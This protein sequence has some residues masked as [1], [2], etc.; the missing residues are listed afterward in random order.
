MNPNPEPHIN[1]F[2]EWTNSC[3]DDQLIHLNVVPLEGQRPY[4]F[5]F[6]SD[7]IP[8]RND[9]RVTSEILKRYQ[10]IEEGGWWCS[11]IDLLSGEEDLWGCFKPSQPR[12][13]YDE[14]KLI[15]YEHP[16]KTPT[17]LFALKIPLHLWQK[18]ASRYQLEILPEDI[19]KNQPD[20]GFWQWFIKHP[21]IPLCITEGAKKAGAL[22]TASYIAIALPGVFGGYRVLRD[23]YG[24]RI[25]KPHLIP[26]LEKL[27]K[28]RREIYI[29]F[30][31]DTKPKTIKNVNAAIRKTGYLLRRKGCNVKVI[32]WNPELGKGVDDLIANQGKNVFDK[33]YE[34]ALLLELWK[35]KSFSRLTYPVNL[36]VNSRYLSEQN[37]FSSLGNNNLH[38]LDNLDL[39]YSTNFPAKLVGIKSAKGTGKTKLLEK[40]VAEA[41]ARHQKVLVIGHR[42]QLV[43]ELC[44]RFGLKYITEVNSESPDKLL[45]LGLCIDSLH[46]N[47][48][49]NFNP[50]TWSD[51]IVI[52]DEIEQVIWH[53]LNSNTC[54]QS[55]VEILRCFKTLMQNVLGGVGQVFIADADLSDISIDYLAALAGIKLEP[56]I[57]QNDW[58]PGEKEAWQIFNYPE[59][60]PK[61]LIA[62]LHKHIREGGKPMVCLSAQKLTSKWGTRALEAYLKKQFPQLKILRIDS[63]SLAEPNHPA[64]GCIKSLNQVLPK[65]DIV[66]AS[67]SIETGVSIDIQGHFTSVWGIAQGVQ[68]ATSVC[69]SLG[70]VRENI[71]RYLWVAN[72]GFNKVGNGSTSITSLLNSEERLTQLNIRL[73]QQSDFDSL[74]DLEVN[75]QPESF[76]CWAKMAVRFNAGMN[77]YRESVL[78]FLQK[79][80]HQ[81]R[82]I[83]TEVLSD[84][85]EAEKS[86]ETPTEVN[87]FQEVIATVIKQNYQSECEAIATAKNISLS[88]YE[89]LKK[90]L[91]KPIQKQREQRKFQLM[92]RY[93][94]PITTELVEK[95]DEGWYEQLEL[96]YFLT[97]G[98]PYLGARDKEV[99][100]KLLDLGKGNIFIPDFNDCLLGAIIGVM[101][102]LKIPSLLKDK[103]RE[104]K[105]IDPDLQL[106]GKTALSNRN[107]IKTI[108]GIGLAANSSPITIVRRFLEKIGYSLECL[109][110]ETHQK[111]RLRIYRIVNPDDGRFEIFQ[112]WL[113]ASQ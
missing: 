84:N 91:S 53:G 68:G 81:I 57:I 82:E 76:L 67:P 108:L 44:Q 40:I 49:A 36:R 74:D 54:R 31:Q 6:Y 50:E 79:E 101:E 30:D 12:H 113:S 28:D 60:T 43:Q 109:R 4:E 33:V 111:K 39:A 63:E 11:G 16:P 110:T 66:L 87:N 35:A 90:R 51:G 75:F 104:L 106:L 72:S 71:P 19:D 94:I 23:E 78:E 21:Q 25:G 55:R 13:S 77:K 58:L 99:A 88:E 2:Q 1:Y 59:T 5:L 80:G 10:H 56:F 42:V 64:Y 65:Y 73:L 103:K 22:L 98:R 27:I 9:G 48:Q 100:K 38:K 95:D 29:V 47:S 92:L 83:S 69:Q 7:A 112:Q 37:I 102:L 96:H 32:S 85:S 52:I 70:R 34:K 26:Q 86:S 107:E 93:N 41:V 15:K 18:I 89:K 8:R 105:N 20:L 45:G 46:P 62:D 97:V 17:S 61:K 3:V 14:K 24:N